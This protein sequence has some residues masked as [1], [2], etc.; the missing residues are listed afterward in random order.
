MLGHLPRAVG[1]V[2]QRRRSG[3]AKLMVHTQAPS[4]PLSM[5]V[6]SPAFAPSEPIPLKYTADGD[7]LSPPL[8]WHGA[9]P[10][11]K[12]VALVIE[13]AD[14]PTP[15]PLVH[16]IA[17]RLPAEGELEEGALLRRV[18]TG[19]NSSL[20][21]GYLP[22]DPL[23]AHGTHRYAF[24]IFAL[25]DA[26]LEPEKFGRGNLSGWMEGKVLA[27]GCLIGTYERT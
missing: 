12:C 1:A 21:H 22:P 2:L 6:E 13:D 19:Q 5:W 25:S 9:P 4:A 8:R 7:G 11:A 10:E 26:P 23:P 18:E 15:R 16:A 24:E 17:A 14:A 3:E 20:M 27:K